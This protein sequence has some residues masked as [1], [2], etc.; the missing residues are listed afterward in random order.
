[1]TAWS[2]RVREL[3]GDGTLRAATVAVKSL[4]SAIMDVREQLL[5]DASSAVGSQRID[6]HITWS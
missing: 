1:M 5:D 3:V 2:G 6:G 4:L